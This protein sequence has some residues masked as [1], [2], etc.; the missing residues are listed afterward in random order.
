VFRVLDKLD[1]IGPAKVRLELTAGYQD[2]SGDRIPGLGLEDRQ[3]DAIEA[4]LAIESGPRDGV[5]EELRRLFA[6]VE[7]ADDEIEVLARISHQ[8]DVL[9][10]GEDRAALDVSIARGLGY[11]T[12]PVWEAVLLDAPQFG[13]VFGGGRYDDL[14]MRFLGE[15]V[16]A[17]GG[18]IG[19]DRLLA[20]LVHLGRLQTRHSTAEVLVTVLDR[21]MLD[22]YLTLTWELRRAGIPTELYLGSGRNPGKQMKYADRTGVPLALLYGPDEKARGVVA[23]KDLAAGRERSQEIEGREQWVQ[24][25]PGQRDVPR[26]GLVPALRELLEQ[27]RA[28]G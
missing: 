19:V 15:R 6:G 12:G 14:V 21:S 28:A 3:V 5:L 23:V 10:Y 17:T 26:E 24:E 2:E 13:S 18:S 9:G 7:G 27:I 8:L 4:F 1:K 20:A 25:R 11:Y 16:P 22:D